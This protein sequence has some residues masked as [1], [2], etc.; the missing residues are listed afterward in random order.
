MNREEAKDIIYSI[1]RL[2][3]FIQAKEILYNAEHNECIKQEMCR[4]QKQLDYVIE[5]FLKEFP[6]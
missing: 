3:R 5:E 6:E 1:C 2:T 4:N